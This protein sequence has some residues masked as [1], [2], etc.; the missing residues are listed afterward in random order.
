MN[1]TTKHKMPAAY[2]LREELK[3][4]LRKT[5]Y[6]RLDMLLS[7]ITTVESMQ[8]QKAWVYGRDGKT[9]EEFMDSFTNKVP[10]HKWSEGQL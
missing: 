7:I 1:Y 2:R 10:Y 8:L 5:D 4:E 6:D 3:Q 9:F